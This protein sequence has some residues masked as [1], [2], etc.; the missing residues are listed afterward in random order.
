MKIT[1][2]KSLKKANELLRSGDC[3]EVILDFNISADEFFELADRW[4][5]KGAK[6][7]KEDGRFII[8]LAK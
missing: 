4:A 7:K 3:R 2:A 1:S 5:E 8:R 6:I